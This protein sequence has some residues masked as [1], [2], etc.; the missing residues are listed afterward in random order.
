MDVKHDS[1][2]AV[3]CTI[4]NSALYNFNFL[5]VVGKYHNNVD[6]CNNGLLFLLQPS[7]MECFCLIIKESH[8]VSFL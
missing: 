6:L 3:I 1:P 8:N 5:F 4:Y 2:F 7:N